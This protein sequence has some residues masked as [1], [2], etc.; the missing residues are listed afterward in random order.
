M[1]KVWYCVADVRA[2]RLMLDYDHWLEGEAQLCTD[3]ES[4]WLR[5]SD[6]RFL[7][8]WLRR[9][10]ELGEPLSLTPNRWLPQLWRPAWSPGG[11]LSGGHFPEADWALLI[12]LDKWE[13]RPE[14]DERRRPPFL[15]AIW[16]L[17]SSLGKDLA[18]KIVQILWAW[19]RRPYY[20]DGGWFLWLFVSPSRVGEVRKVVSRLRFEYE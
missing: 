7:G 17:S 15:L 4:W 9:A 2:A 13:H 16:C 8:P 20:R 19:E 12:P 18:R 10:P 6:R 14:Y 1:G 11:D 3:G 5:S